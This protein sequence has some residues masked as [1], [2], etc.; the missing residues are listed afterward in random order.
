MAVLNIIHH[1]VLPSGTPAATPVYSKHMP[2]LVTYYPPG[3]P[4]G[5]STLDFSA[6][7]PKVLYSR[8][9][10]VQELF[11]DASGRE[12]VSNAVVYVCEEVEIGGFLFKSDEGAI[13]GSDPNASAGSRQVRGISVSGNLRRTTEL[14]KVWL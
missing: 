12:L 9:Q 4:D 3:A 10:D 7:T 13:I 2:D 8:W 14:H 11:R 6:V 1:F 5:F